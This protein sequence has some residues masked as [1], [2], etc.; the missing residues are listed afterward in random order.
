MNRAIVTALWRQRLTSPMRILF[1]GAVFFPPVGVA[2]MMAA[3]A[4]LHGLAAFFALVLAAGAIGQDVSSGVLQL[5]FA[6]PLSRPSYVTSRWLAAAVGGAALGIAQLVL[7]SAFLAL[8]GAAPGAP[9]LLVSMLTAVFGA[10]T[11][12]A[13]MIGL[14]S[15][16]NGLGDVALYGLAVVSLPIARQIAMFRHWPRVAQALDEL[17]RTIKPAIELGWLI[18]HGTPDWTD[19]VTAASTIALSLAIA[20]VVVNRKELSYATD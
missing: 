6:R 11:G 20:I 3:L 15:L 4:P 18:G 16:V 8:R 5:T 9:E 13:V 12:A 14:S 7:A 17:S 10:F 2:T 1:I 19:L